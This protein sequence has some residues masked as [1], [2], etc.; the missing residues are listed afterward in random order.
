[1]LVLALSLMPLLAGA[2]EAHAPA[3]AAAPASSPAAPGPSQMS[4]Y[5]TENGREV[6]V[7]LLS[8]DAQA[9]VVA[10]A[11]SAA[12]TLGELNDG[13]S[14]AHKD[15]Q[16]GTTKQ[17]DFRPVLDRIIDMRLMVLEARDMGLDDLPDVKEAIQQ[18]SESK[19]IGTVRAHAIEGV[20]ADP[21]EEQRF[22]QDAVREWQLRSLLFPKGEDAQAFLAEMKPKKA[23]FRAAA[24]KFIDAKKASGTDEATYMPR[25]RMLPQVLSAVTKMKKG[26]IEIVRVNDGW[27]V[28]QVMGFRYPEDAEER[29]RARG[30]ALELAQQRAASKLYQG[31]EKKY[32]RVDKKLLARLDFEAPKP[33]FAAL[34]KDKRVLA[35]I[36]GEA[37]LAVADLAHGLEMKF[38]HGIEAPIKEKRLNAATHDVFQTL[39]RRRLVLHEAARQKLASS[40]EYRAYMDRFTEATLFTAYVERV[41]MPDVKV[42]EDE[43]RKYF[44]S[45]RSEFVVPTMYRLDSIVFEKAKDAQS[46]LQKLHA[47]TDF[48]WLRTNATGQV[49]EDK[50][51]A[52]LDGTT[53]SANALPE[54]LRTQL[55]GARVGDYRMQEI[56]GQFFVVRVASRTD[57]QEPSY[58]QVRSEIGKK[59]I[60]PDFT[61]VL[62]DAAAKLRRNHEVAVYLTKIGF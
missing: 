40:A 48:K 22:Y 54:G 46:A 36:V 12:V 29:A 1:M 51:A 62:K 55:A 44:A 9:K 39:L 33:G 26:R 37:P 25:A 10:R 58:E 49:A 56:E 11:G 30:R 52:E 41:I 18:E 32:A 57:G 2:A 21:R 4:A 53:V 31:L 14:L 23:D 45:H 50:R 34:K 42:S 27:A 16:P 38:F 61:R 24:R 7:P 3:A 28:V 60:G 5:L 6:R 59:L 8:P 15:Y 19:L 13:L 20:K 47:G 43:G 17:H 35:R